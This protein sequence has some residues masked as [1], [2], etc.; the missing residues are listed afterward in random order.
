MGKKGSGYLRKNFAAF[1]ASAKIIPVIL[2][3]DLDTFRCPGDL[4]ASWLRIVP[5]T[6]M[7]FQI[8]VREIE[9]WLLSDIEG[10]CGFLRVKQ[11]PRIEKPDEL[12]DAKRYLLS[13]SLQ[14]RNR[15]TRDSIVYRDRRS[16]TLIQGRDYN[17]VLS[18]FVYNT[19]NVN[20]AISRSKSL[21]RFVHVLDTFEEA[22]SREQ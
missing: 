17:G 1:N 3:T 16:G 9:A 6:N 8:A 18:D 7:L 21:A 5:H 4:R 15:T 10:Y 19:W 13:L 12:P 22:Y 14:S 2:I 11:I 20:G